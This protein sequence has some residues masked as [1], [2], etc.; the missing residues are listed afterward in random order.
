MEP[1]SEFAFMLPLTNIEPVMVWLPTNVLL[2]VV[3]KL[4]NLLSTDVEKGVYKD[5]VAST[6]ANLLSTDVENGMWS[7]AVDCNIPTEVDIEA[8]YAWT[9]SNLL[10]TDVENDEVKFSKAMV[11]LSKL[12]NLVPTLPT[13]DPVKLPVI[14]MSPF[15]VSNEPVYGVIEFTLSILIFFIKLLPN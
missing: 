1:V 13:D 9:E 11:S 12:L 6:T 10:L 2:P 8:V 3:A 14:I 15:T 7:D 4:T 5:A